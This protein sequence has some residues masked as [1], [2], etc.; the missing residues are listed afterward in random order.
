MKRPKVLYYYLVS[1]LF[2]VRLI[3]AQELKT[4][5]VLNLD[6]SG[7]T[8]QEAKVITDRI[9]STLPRLGVYNVQER[10]K[11]EAIFDE[12]KFQLSGCTSEACVVEAGQLLGAEK[13]LYGSVGHLGDFFTLELFILDVETGSIEH[14]SSF[15]VEGNIGQLLKGSETAL[16]RLLDIAYSDNTPSGLAQPKGTNS[17][18]VFNVGGRLDVESVPVGAYVFLDGKEL[19]ETPLTKQNIKP[20]IHILLLRLENYQDYSQNIQMESGQIEK[21]VYS[22]ESVFGELQI[23]IQNQPEMEILFNEEQMNLGD[24]PI[25]NLAQGVY[26]LTISCSGFFPVDTTVTIFSNEITELDLDLKVEPFADL[27]VYTN[28]KQATIIINNTQYDESPVGIKNIKLGNH[29]EIEIS[30]DHFYTITDSFQIVSATQ[31]DKQYNLEP[32]MGALK[33]ETDFDDLTL[34]VNNQLIRQF[35]K[36]IELQQGSHLLKVTKE[37]YYPYEELV[38]IP[39]NGM[40]T[41]RVKLTYALL[42]HKRYKKHRNYALIA[43]IG[44]TAIS[45]YASLSADNAYEWYSN[46]STMQQAE[47]YKKKT[48]N[49]DILFVSALTAGAGAGVYSV[50]LQ[51]KIS[52]IQKLAGLK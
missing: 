52:D 35:I 25:R 48:Q 28:P 42:D 6:P 24:F 23:N 47:K 38:I 39:D 49:A 41:R 18:T 20:G 34:S 22:L 11:M 51:F 7:L 2:I 8:N 43:T 36:P 50:F 46:A 10:G 5:S 4:I 32:M 13:M 29:F 37:G 33:I 15:E 16:N 26:P 9:R 30:K 3:Y 17:L 45:L 12:M 27:S 14:T 40:V 31:I 1:L 44:A 19:G 21:V